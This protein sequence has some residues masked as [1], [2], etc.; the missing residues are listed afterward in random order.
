MTS[1][2][3][4]RTIV[5]TG[6]RYLGALPPSEFSGKLYATLGREPPRNAL[7]VPA[8]GD[9]AGK[10]IALL[11]NGWSSFAKIVARMDDALRRRY[12]VA[13]VRV[14]RISASSAVP[15][16]L[17]DRIVAECDAAIVGLAN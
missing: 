7:L 3:L 6:A 14:H 13:A 4:L 11:D 12:G 2:S 15:P 8:V 10:T 1:P 16:E 5:E 9:L 17:V